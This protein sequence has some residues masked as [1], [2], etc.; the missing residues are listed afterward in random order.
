MKKLLISIVITL[1]GI[2]CCVIASLDVG[3]LRHISSEELAM[4]ISHAS[5]EERTV[6]LRLLAQRY[7][8]PGEPV[9]DG[10]L[11]PAE[12]ALPRD[13]VVSSNL[14]SSLVSF[15][16]QAAEWQDR[17]E[18]L[19]VVKMLLSRTNII[20][21]FGNLL[22]S[23]CL[24]VRLDSACAV[25][26][27]CASHNLSIPKSSIDSLGDILRSK[28]SKGELCAALECISIAG[29]GATNRF[30]DVLVLT[31]SRSKQVRAA[32]RSA[33]RSIER[34]TVQSPSIDRVS[35]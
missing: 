5:S 1:F 13:A 34:S 17:K 24:Q 10:G 20:P 8:L 7:R 27:Y 2:C 11:Y 25:V 19:S 4:R 6:I 29:A 22:R 28:A 15:T 16:S 35:P 9:I 14:V 32:A 26:E 3:E 21:M 31:K 12:E 23:S 18:A 33:L 30:S